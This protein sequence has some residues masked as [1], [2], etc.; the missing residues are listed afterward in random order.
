MLGCVVIDFLLTWLLL[1]VCLVSLRAVCIV[2]I[3]WFAC[4]VLA[5]FD[6][7]N[8]LTLRLL[9]GLNDL[10]SASYRVRSVPFFQAFPVVDSLFQSRFLLLSHLCSAAAWFALASRWCLG[11][12]PWFGLWH[13]LS[14]SPTCRRFDPIKA[15]LWLWLADCSLRVD[16]NVC[17]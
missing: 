10:H 3:A 6:S 11:H 12:A 4:L 8:F 16:Q 15:W 7:C 9:A 14:L 5:R 2:S 1:I 13:S 17:W